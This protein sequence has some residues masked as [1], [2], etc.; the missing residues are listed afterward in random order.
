MHTKTLTLPE[1]G[2]IIATRAALGAGIGLLIGEKLD[3][4]TRRAL[5]VTL[6]GLGAFTTI[7]AALVL[8]RR[9]SLAAG[10]FSQ[11]DNLIGSRRFARKGNEI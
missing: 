2:F 5:G 6:V 1:L 9:G 10:D 4:T 3:A 7:P 8:F 11:S